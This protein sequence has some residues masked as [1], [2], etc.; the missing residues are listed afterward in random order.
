MIKN[1]LVSIIMPAYNSQKFICEAIES[2]INQSHTNWELIIIN[3]GSTDMTR[4][5]VESYLE[6]KRIRI[7]DQENLG[8]SK[9]RNCGLSI[10]KG[11]FFCFLDSDD[12]LPPKSIS[13]RL[14]LMSDKYVY[15]VDGM[16]Q[17]FDV[18]M[19]QV[20]SIYKP[21]FR[22]SPKEELLKLSSKCFFGVTWM[23]RRIP[24]QNYSFNPEMKHAEDLLFYIQLS[25]LGGNY[26]YVNEPTYKRRIVTGSAMSN[27]S[28][29]I[30]GYWKLYENIL[31]F[32]LADTNHLTILRHKIR[33]LILKISIRK[34][35]L[36]L[37][38][39]LFH[40]PY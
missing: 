32:E 22:G 12:M 30:Q 23:I 25:D 16:V 13:S 18:Q 2:V 5:Q 3:D 19:K 37:L 6:D 11:D 38:K 4:E 39:Y 10:M 34:G 9:A 31:R 15:F 7:V 14:E 8:V 27:V 24:D 1:N 36:G 33:L 28:G 29:L 26:T 17:S 35:K 20:K 40:A 21:E